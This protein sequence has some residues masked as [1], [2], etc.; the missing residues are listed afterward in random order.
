M[1]FSDLTSLELNALD[2]VYAAHV[3]L[4]KLVS[5]AEIEEYMEGLGSEVSISPRLL[6]SLVRKGALRAF[7]GK[8][9]SIYYGPTRALSKSRYIKSLVREDTEDYEFLD[10]KGGYLQESEEELEDLKNSL[11]SKGSEYIELPKVSGVFS[12]S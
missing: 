12:K 7:R 6:L 3:G 10:I 9:S 1:D 11:L 2:A 5:L 4:G 8:D